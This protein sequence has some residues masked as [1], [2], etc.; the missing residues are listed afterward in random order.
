MPGSTLRIENSTRAHAESLHLLLAGY[1]ARLVQDGQA[2]QVEVKLG[3]LAS[4]LAS[5]FDALGSWL[6]TEQVDSVLLRFDE[7]QFT[8]LRPSP[9]RL[10]DSNAFL[11]ERVAQLETALQT[12][13]VLEQAKGILSL[14]LGCDPE[15]AFEALRAAARDHGATIRGLAARIVAAPAEARRML[16]SPSPPE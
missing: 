6:E 7:R 4:L 11:L 14:T 5:L 8:L 15:Q 9:D 10:V 1:P 12:R 2:W 3:E 16:A 13:I